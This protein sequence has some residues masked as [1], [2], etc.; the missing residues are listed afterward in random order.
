M[1]PLV[2]SSTE[3]CRILAD[4]SVAAGALRPRQFEEKTYYRLDYDVILLFGL[5]ELKAQ[6]GWLENVCIS[7][8]LCLYVHQ[9]VA[10]HTGCRKEV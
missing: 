1:T 2:A 3:Q 8:T 5:T 4:T 10:K 7:S 6:I 9:L